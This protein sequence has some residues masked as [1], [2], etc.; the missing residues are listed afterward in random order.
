MF[1]VSI[2][3]DDMCEMFEYMGYQYVNLCF[4]VFVLLD[5]GKNNFV[6]QFGW[7]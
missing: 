7:F 5:V 3:M 1:E 6:K 4:S 2:C